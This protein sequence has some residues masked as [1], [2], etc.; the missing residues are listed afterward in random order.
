MR[1]RC[2]ERFEGDGWF[3]KGAADKKQWREGA[4]DRK[5]WR[6]GADDS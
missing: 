6:K 5:Q 1:G 2:V 4:A 3:W